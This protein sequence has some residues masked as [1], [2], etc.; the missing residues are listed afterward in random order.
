ML[1]LI[2]IFFNAGTGAASHAFNNEILF[3]TVILMSIADAAGALV[4]AHFAN[5]INEDIR[6][7]L[8]GVIIFGRGIVNLVNV[9]V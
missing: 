8:I 4:S 2:L 9:L 1:A 7:H 6:A 3:N 5:R